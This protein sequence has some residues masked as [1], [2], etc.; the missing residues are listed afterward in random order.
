MLYFEC[1]VNGVLS[2][3][4]LLLFFFDVQLFFIFFFYLFAFHN[5]G[6]VVGQSTSFVGDELNTSSRCFKKYHDLCQLSQV[7][8]LP[9]YLVCNAYILCYYISGT[10][11]LLLKRSQCCLQKFS[12]PGEIIQSLWWTTSL[13]HH[14]TK[15]LPLI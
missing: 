13:V 7:S 15:R 14:S 9:K 12:S 5:L 11:D 2:R 10:S 3:F 6:A 8:F 4:L 1:V